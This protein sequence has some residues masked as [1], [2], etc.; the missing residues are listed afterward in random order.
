MK[1]LGY[2]HNR[3]LFYKDTGEVSEEVFE[4]VSCLVKDPRCQSRISLSSLLM[5]VYR[6]FQQHGSYS[7]TEAADVEDEETFEHYVQCLHYVQLPEHQLNEDLL[8]KAQAKTSTPHDTPPRPHRTLNRLPNLVAE[9]LT[10]TM[11]RTGSLHTGPRRAGLPPREC[12]SSG[13]PR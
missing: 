10:L 2:A 9:N 12:P 8:A 3:M 5:G 11:Q 13:G 1:D 6:Q 7:L 4:I